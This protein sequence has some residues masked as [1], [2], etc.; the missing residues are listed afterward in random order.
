M[1]SVRKEL[2]SRFDAGPRKIRRGEEQD[3]D[4]CLLLWSWWGRGKLPRL[5]NYMGGISD[6]IAEENGD[7]GEWHTS[8]VIHGTGWYYWCYIR[9]RDEVFG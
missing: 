8:Q 7:C 9:R 5:F 1:A 4:Y 2:E 3:L 6:L